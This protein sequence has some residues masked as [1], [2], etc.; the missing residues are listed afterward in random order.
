MPRKIASNDQSA[1]SVVAYHIEQYALISIEIV[2]FSIFFP[3]EMCE[4]DIVPFVILI[5]R[6]SKSDNQIRD[7]N[8]N[9]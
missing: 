9:D 7:D 2:I 6:S 5:A 3:F 8:I 1:S 4:T